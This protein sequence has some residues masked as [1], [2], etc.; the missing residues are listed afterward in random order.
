M[1]LLQTLS[2]AFCLW[3][4]GNSYCNVLAQ[5]IEIS[6][7]NPDRIVRVETALNHLTVIE[8]PE[9]ITTVA[10]GS[11]A[12]KIE[13]RENKVFTQPLEEGESTNLFIWTAAH[14]YSYELA[15][16]GNVGAMHFA[17]D[18]KE[19]TSTASEDSPA[20]PKT[21]SNEAAS[22]ALL[23]SIPVRWQ[24]SRPDENRVA[25]EFRDVL[26]LSDRWLIRYAVVNRSAE[27]YPLH[28][29]RIAVMNS[30]V[31]KLSLLPLFGVQL[32]PREARHVRSDDQQRLNA[33][34]SETGGDFVVPGREAIGV[35][36][37]A[38][39]AETAKPSVLQFEFPADQRGRVTAMLV[40]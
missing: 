6:P 19:S 20:E 35:V 14:R 3:I 25:V 1:S 40:L 31:S 38:P 37:I 13:R 29:P 16:A 12:F 17:I 15:P 23:R 18:H 28:K 30:P 32:G 9:A 10:A 7:A 8:V 4:L 2:L 22:N 5:K 39:L 34:Q 26:K 36:G 33:I 11:P 21:E 27:S 24:G